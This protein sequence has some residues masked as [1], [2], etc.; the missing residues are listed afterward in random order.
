MKRLRLSAKLALAI[1]PIGVVALVAA[2]FIAFTFLSDSRA[3]SE[4]AHAAT[5]AAGAIDTLKAVWDEEAQA[6]Q[7]YLF[8]NADRADGLAS[9]IERTD[10][11][12]QDLRDSTAEL[13]E[14]TAGFFNEVAF[15]A[16]A[17]VRRISDTLNAMRSINSPDATE[18]RGYHQV[19][20]AI[21]AVLPKTS[22][23]V[24]DRLQARE[25]STAYFLAE[26]GQVS[27]IQE[28]LIEEFRAAALA[29]PEFDNLSSRGS[30]QSTLEV[31]EGEFGAW[32][33]RANQ[34]AN[35]MSAAILRYTRLPD[36]DLNTFPLRRNEDIMNTSES[37]AQAVADNSQ[38]SAA[39]SQRE[40]Y[41][42]A[43]VAAGILLIALFGSYAVIR[44]V[45]RRVRGVT[46]AAVRVSEEDLPALVDALQNPNEDIGDLKPTRIEA[47]GSDEVGELAA[48]F[49]NLHA[50]LI[51]V[52]S[53]QMD[54]LRKGVSEIFV[55]LA[56]RNRSLVDRQLALLDELE[57][58]EEDPETLGGYYNLDHLATRMRRNAE[59]LLV[60]AG[61]EPTR[62]WSKPLEVSEIIRAA[63]GEVDDYQR[64]DIMALEPA[65]VSGRAVADVAHLMSEL[66]DNGTQ[67]S[68]PVDRVR[69]AGLYDPDGY[70]LTVSDSGIGISNEKIAEFNALLENPPVLGLALQPTLGM[71]VV[72]RLAARH[73]IRVQLISGSPGVTVRVLMPK[74]LLEAATADNDGR[75][76][77][78]PVAYRPAISSPLHNG[79]RS[80]GEESIAA[81]P[82]DD[83]V[84]APAAETTLPGKIKGRHEHPGRSRSVKVDRERESRQVSPFAEEL[85]SGSRIGELKKRVP[86]EALWLEQTDEAEVAEKAVLQ[87]SWEVHAAPVETGNDLLHE[88]GHAHEETEVTYAQAAADPAVVSVEPADSEDAAEIL[89]MEASE[90]SASG[91]PEVKE[92]SGAV[93][94]PWWVDRETSG[95]A[96]VDSPEDHQPGEQETQAAVQVEAADHPLTPDLPPLGKPVEEKRTKITPV[97]LPVRTPGV[98]FRDTDETATSSS[99]S[100]SGAIGIKSALTDFNDGRALASQKLD[101][102]EDDSHDEEGRDE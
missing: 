42:V 14:N 17:D 78:P 32:A 53:Q 30:L 73:G 82:D 65:L 13:G 47:A 26:G 83:G 89:E 5:V 21:L 100:R 22:S 54:I 58:R 18:I 24:S 4:T 37:M 41:L 72:A 75:D 1:I 9:A 16:S 15:S 101:A 51:D 39:D 28:Q 74:A 11:A 66:L 50:T 29:N 23:I 12:L 93:E 70:M 62:I 8:D 38:V 19:A 57:S 49:T 61:S 90:A 87:V 6:R 68:S 60:L 67:F 20:S 69:V 97:G 102:R 63:L 56:R 98:S 36:V 79:A 2:G 31:L 10:D 95:P 92:D 55:T 64:V 86:G 34:T 3:Q 48:S 77:L 44:S 7:V 52:A 94:Q 84:S 43:G 88:D 85:G 76:S 80:P 99:A 96:A 25:L 71:Y 27:L 40:A 81:A 46:D 59:S 91:D 35:Q 33:L 45:V